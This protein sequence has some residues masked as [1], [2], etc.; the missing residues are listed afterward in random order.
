MTK[1]LT[2]ADQLFLKRLGEKIRTIIIR[3]KG[4]SSLDAFAL[5]HHDDIAKGTLYEVCEGQ[6]DMKISTLRGLC[7][8]LDLTVEDLI[9]GV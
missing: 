5:E 6:R 1:K 4:Y 2:K 8:A 7:R 9:R 3:E